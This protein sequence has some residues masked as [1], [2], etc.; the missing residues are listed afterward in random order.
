MGVLLVVGV[1]GGDVGEVFAPGDPQAPN[2]EGQG[3]VGVDELKLPGR[4]RAEGRAICW[5]S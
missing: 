3:G 4:Y 1:E 2:P 5:P